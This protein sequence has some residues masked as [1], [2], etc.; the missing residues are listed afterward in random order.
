MSWQ[1]EIRNPNCQLCLLHEGAD[2]V[3]LMGTGPRTADIMVVGE[4]PG[5][6]ED[7]THQAFVGK[8]GELLNEG[9]AAAGISR[10]DCVITN[11]AKCKP[12]RNRT[13]ERSEIKRCIETYLKQELAVVQPKYMLAMGNSAFQGLLGKSGIT[14]HHGSVFD[15]DGM[16]VM[17]TIHPALV[18]RNPAWMTAFRTDLTRFGKMVRGEATSPTTA[19][20]VVRRK[21]QL[22]WLLENLR[23]AEEISWDIETWVDTSDVDPPYKRPPGQY[24]HNDESMITSIGFSWEEGQSA[25]IPLWHMTPTWRDPTRVLLYL[26][27]VMERDDCKYI[28]HNGKF[29]ASWLWS[30]GIHVRQDFDTM[31]A[32]HMLEENRP[33]GLK[34]LSR[35]E[36]GADAYDVGEDKKDTYHTPLRR[37]CIY[38]GK[39]TDYTLRLKHV[40]AD[41][42]REE[43]RAARVFKLL[44]MPAS[45]A[46]VDVERQG[47]YL[48]MDRWSDRR[49]VCEANRAKIHK[50]INQFWPHES[51]INLNA[52]QQVGRL[53]FE[54]LRLPII[55]KTAKG[56]NSTKESVLLELASRG[57]KVPTALIKWRKWNGYITRYL[58]PWRYEWTD[59]DGRLHCIYKLYG[60]VTGRLSGEGGIQQVPRDPLIRSIIGAEPGWLFVQ[61]DYSQIELR[62]AAWLANEKRMLRAFLRGDDIHMLRAMRMTGKPAHL[63]TKEERKKSKAVNFGFLYGMGAKKFVTYAFENYDVRVTLPEAEAV[64]DGFFN[65][66]PAL[67]TWHDRQRRLARRYQRV[68]SPIGRVRHLPDINSSD[69]SV[70]QEAERQAINSPVQSCASDIMLT[71]LITMHP[72][73]DPREAR[74]V[75]T[76]HDSILFE[77]R[78]D[79]LDKTLPFIKETMEDMSLVKS[80][81]GT[82]VGVPINVDIEVGTH[83]GE[84][85]PWQEAA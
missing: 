29:D 56:A 14:K 46:L 33:K 7:E 5:Q 83:W 68:T 61:G 36:L 43:P 41:R 59:D 45:N 8:S 28:A 60:T 25:V 42:L 19:I 9:L 78:K 77:I 62:I 52:P 2:H 15:L 82:E 32:A 71:S 74:I 54:E 85:T 35:T 20:K 30:K 11:V 79:A 58:D 64:R 67:R 84:G 26:K 21:A 39:D 6:R 57:H 12:P 16:K 22:G 49:K 53:L 44:M 37:L 76:V 1:D 51:P 10:G 17:V 18:L 38:N 73:L 40:L 81:F 48:D 72:Q 24:W 31:L 50:Y 4:A 47:V 75:G 70:K 80:K 23:V 34:P 66:Y 69:E 65:D 3:C 13:P 63:V 55:E 27:E